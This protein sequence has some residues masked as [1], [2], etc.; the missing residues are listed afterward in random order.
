MSNNKLVYL[1]RKLT[2]NSVFYVGMGSHYRPFE[3]KKRS[4]FWKKVDKKYGTFVDVVKRN[5]SRDDAYELEKT[6]IE[7]YGRRDKN[8]GM[9]VN[10][11]DGGDGGLG[12]IQTEAHISKRLKT[13]TDNGN[14]EL[15]RERML[16]RNKESNPCVKF[17]IVCVNDGNEFG[18]IREAGR[19]Y[20]IDNSYISKHLKGIYKNVKGL[21]F[22][23]IV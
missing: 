5:M 19:F 4:L 14:I 23:N 12:A 20:N 10:M 11:T 16:A 8:E 13:W 22:N 3:T 18:S 15:S 9:L 2:D 6:L 1:H 17:S 7:H 21:I